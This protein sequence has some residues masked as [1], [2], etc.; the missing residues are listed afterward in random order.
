MRFV[1]G[2]E[3]E[4]MQISSDAIEYRPGGLRHAVDT[5]ALEF[6]P[7]GVLAYAVCGRPVRLWSK[8]AFDEQIA[9]STAHEDCVKLAVR[10]KRP[11]AVAAD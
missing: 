3:L 11:K 7:D 4:E 9:K 2:S 10:A 8:I 6:H 5:A 1:L